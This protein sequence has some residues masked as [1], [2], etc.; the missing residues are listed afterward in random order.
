MYEI[1]F[2]ISLFVVGYYLGQVIALGRVNKEYEKDK[3]T[4][5]DNF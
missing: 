2:N 4:E 3:E 1:L 5:N